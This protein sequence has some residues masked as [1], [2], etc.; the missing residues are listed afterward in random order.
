MKGFGTHFFRNSF[1][2]A[3]RSSVQE[4]AIQSEATVAPKPSR[5]A[6][7][8]MLTIRRLCPEFIWTEAIKKRGYFD[9][10][11]EFVSESIIYPNTVTGFF[12]ASQPVNKEPQ[13]GTC[14]VYSLGSKAHVVQTQTEVF[15]VIL[16]L[17]ENRKASCARQVT[18]SSGVRR[19]EEL[20]RSR[21]PET[22]L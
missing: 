4:P 10:S 6:S 17:F 5:Y 9:P 8:V 2:G 13:K 1:C 11:Q 15:F 3:K 18:S 19:A 20:N 21:S 22:L 12:K 14:A 7:V 16:S